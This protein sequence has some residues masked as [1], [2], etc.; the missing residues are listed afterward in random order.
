VINCS[1]KIEKSLR[2]EP[3]AFLPLHER[4]TIQRP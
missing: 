4:G 1:G 2:R 3:E